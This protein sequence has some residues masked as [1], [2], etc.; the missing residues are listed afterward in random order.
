MFLG[1]VGFGV[2]YWLTFFRIRRRVAVWLTEV[3]MSTKRT[4][5]YND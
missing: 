5:D 4:D 3:F 1:R 2:A